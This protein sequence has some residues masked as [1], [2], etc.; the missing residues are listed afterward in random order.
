MLSK[1]TVIHW[2]RGDYS[3]LNIYFQGNISLLDS[4]AWELKSTIE[5]LNKYSVSKPHQ[6]A[7]HQRAQRWPLSSWLMP[8]LP[9]KAIIVMDSLMWRTVHQNQSTSSCHIG[10]HL[11]NQHLWPYLKLQLAFL[12]ESSSSRRD[13]LSFFLQLLTDSYISCNF[14]EICFCLSVHDIHLLSLLLKD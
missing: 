2:V 14:S 1:A 9:T 12:L 13:L 8:T 4:K 6:H 11:G 3:Y 5:A 10:R 7:T